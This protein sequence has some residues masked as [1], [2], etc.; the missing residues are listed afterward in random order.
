M[1]TTAAVVDAQTALAWGLAAEVVPEALFT[2]HV[3]DTA[4]R[5]VSLAPRTLRAHKEI[6]RRLVGVFGGIGADD[7]YADC[8]GSDD[9]REGV[10]AFLAKR[11]PAWSG[12]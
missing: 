4:A 8:Y 2:G 9:F 3:E 10:A 1:L 11:T 12:R 5:I 6:D 7:V